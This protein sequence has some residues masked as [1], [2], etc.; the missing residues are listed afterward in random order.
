MG[1]EF[2]DKFKYWRN[3]YGKFKLIIDGNYILQKQL[4]GYIKIGNLSDEELKEFNKLNEQDKQ[5][6]L[7]DFFNFYMAIND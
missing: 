5:Q 1:E 4:K 2:K 7:S 6:F 3:R